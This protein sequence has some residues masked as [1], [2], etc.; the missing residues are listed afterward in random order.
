MK[1]IEQ[2]DARGRKVLRVKQTQ[3]ELRVELARL[4]RR[5]RRFLRLARSVE[6]LNK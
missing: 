2:P 5:H 6:S 4:E 3:E 1:L